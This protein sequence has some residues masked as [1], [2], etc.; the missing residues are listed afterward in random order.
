MEEVRYKC[1]SA[2]VEGQRKVRV[3]YTSARNAE[4]RARN[5]SIA[6]AR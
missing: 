3:G 4:K 1:A 5:L 6:V 2:A